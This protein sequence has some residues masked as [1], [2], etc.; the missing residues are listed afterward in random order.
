MT[1]VAAYSSKLLRKV[2]RW[3]R[4]KASTAPS[5]VTPAKA[6]STTDR[7][8][9]AAVASRAIADRKVL[10]SPP[11]FAAMAGETTDN[12]QTKVAID[13]A[14]MLILVGP[15]GRHHGTR[16]GRAI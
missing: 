16:C 11:H 15:D 5:T 12:A 13:R 4:S 1:R 10:K 9:P 8:T 2:P 7:E 3:R 14:S 6:L